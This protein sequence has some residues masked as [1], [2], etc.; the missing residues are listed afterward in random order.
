MSTA[1]KHLGKLQNHVFHTRSKF[2]FHNARGIKTVTNNREKGNITDNYFKG[3]AGNLNLKS[4]QIKNFET[5]SNIIK[6]FEIMK[7]SSQL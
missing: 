7:V 5:F 2:Q 1:T 4:N 6:T 3:I